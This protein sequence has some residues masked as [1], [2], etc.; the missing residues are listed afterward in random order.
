MI[1]YIIAIAV[2]WF[3]FRISTKKDEKFFH[4]DFSNIKPNSYQLE[5]DNFITNLK[6]KKKCSP[7]A[8]DALE[9][10][11]MIDYIYHTK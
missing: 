11:R 9:I 6:N 5:I 8:H 10:M 3:L 7:N 1:K 2:L 4:K